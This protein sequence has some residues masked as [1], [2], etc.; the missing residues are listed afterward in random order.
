[1]DNLK[2]IESNKNKQMEV[3]G[4]LHDTLSAIRRY[5]EFER[6]ITGQDYFSPDFITI[7]NTI[8]NKIHREET[9]LSVIQLS[10]RMLESKV[11][12]LLKK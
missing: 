9:A 6:Q 2:E 10:Y 12:G 8:Q 11:K 7:I 1:M 3:I 4:N 5:A